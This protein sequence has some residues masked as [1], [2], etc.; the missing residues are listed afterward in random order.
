MY[1]IFNVHDRKSD[2][3][4]YRK[5]N[6]TFSKSVLVILLMKRCSVPSKS[7]ATHM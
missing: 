4:I 3:G 1:V 7:H 6:F 5:A 2:A